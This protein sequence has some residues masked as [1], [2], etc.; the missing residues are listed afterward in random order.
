V[1]G[2]PGVGYERNVIA[3]IDGTMSPSTEYI[4]DGHFDSI[5]WFDTALARYFAPGAN[6]N[7]SGTAA[8][9]EAAR[10]FRYYSWQATIRFIGWAAEEIGYGGSDHYAR[11]ADSMGKDIGGVVNL[12]MTGHMDA[13]SILDANVEYGFGHGYWLAELFYRV[14]Q[15]YVPSLLI[16]YDQ[17]GGG[18][19]WYPFAVR[20]YPAIGAAE[21]WYYDDPTW[22]DT[23]DVLAHMSPELFTR[24]TKVGVATLAILGSYPSRVKDVAVRDMGDG[25]R[26]LV[27][28]SAN[29]EGNIAGYEVYWGRQSQVYA[30]S[31]F[32]AGIAHTTDTLSGL[33][34]D[35]T[36]YIIVAA[37]SIDKHVASFIFRNF[38][39]LKCQDMPENF[40]FR[41]FLAF[42]YLF[43]N[44]P[45]SCYKFR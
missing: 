34:A 21:R 3:T 45:I 24:I 22:H 18:S 5:I 41:Y 20:G 37:A 42:K 12:D 36:Y 29:T 16:Y 27:T 1:G 6:D 25:S 19:D 26:L 9:L 39:K 43:I 31:H 28:W 13:D 32:A 40:P 2:W 14:G 35:S 11:M 23:S 33:K 44:W 4:I 7:G 38:L 10:I 17:S 8:A 30:D 15:L